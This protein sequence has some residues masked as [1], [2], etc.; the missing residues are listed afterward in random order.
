[1]CHSPNFIDDD[2]IH[3]EHES[4]WCLHLTAVEAMIPLFFCCW[5][6][7]LCQKCTLPSS[8][9]I[10]STRWR[11]KHFVRG[12]HTMH[13]NTGVF[14]GLWSDMATFMRCGHSKLRIVGIILKP[15][16]LKIWAY[17]LHTC[18]TIVYDVNDMRSEDSNKSQYIHKGF[19]RNSWERKFLRMPITSVD[20]AQLIRSPSSKCGRYRT[21]A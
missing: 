9:Y 11:Q 19:L 15:Q 13:H 12:E 18:H 16:T 8:R 14:N 21:G 5:V 6:Y 10:W 4:D 3:A 1:M 2:H 7:E 20:L 17:S